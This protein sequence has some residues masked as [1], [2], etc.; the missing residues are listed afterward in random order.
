MRA[1]ASGIGGGLVRVLPCGEAAPAAAAARR[2]HAS[3]RSGS[4]APGPRRR[5]AGFRSPSVPRPAAPATPGSGVWPL[6]RPRP[7]DFLRLRM[8]GDLRAH[9]LG[10]ARDELGRGKAL[11]GE[12]VAERLVQKVRQR[13]RIRFAGLVHVARL[14]HIVRHDASSWHGTTKARRRAAGRPERRR[15]AGLVRS[16]SP[17]AAV[18]RRAAA[19][20]PIPTASGSPRSCCS[21]PRSR[22]SAP[23][24]ARFTAR[25]SD[26]RA[27]AAA[28]LD[29]VLKLW[30]GLGYYARARNLHACAKAVVERHGGRFPQSRGGA[31]RAA[32]HRPLHGG[33]DRGH[34]LRRAAQRRSTAMSSGW[35][36]GC[37]RSKRYCPAAKP[38][39]RRLTE[40]L[41]PR[42][43]AGDFA[44]A[45]MDLGATICTPKKPACA[46]CPWMEHC[47]ARARGD[48]ETFPL[49]APK[50]EGRLRRG[51]AFVV[52]RADGFV[53]V[54]SRPPKGLLGG[55]TEVPTNEWSARLR[56]EQC[57]ARGAAACRARRR[58]GCARSRR[59]DA[60][61][62]AFSARTHRLHC[63]VSA[64]DARRQPAC[65]GW[66]SPI[67]P[68]KRCPISCARCSRMRACFPAEARRPTDGARPDAKPVFTSL[69]RAL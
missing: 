17:Q 20:R 15:S 69:A 23:Y 67:C 27:L 56:R 39:I 43:R 53:L 28:P 12:R 35:W 47:A 59:R 52:M 30:A 29:D 38:D 11:L 40:A 9:D 65:A 2:P 45:L 19:R 68:A 64:P 13:T 33:G 14:C 25:W 7:L 32:R 21:R 8:G 22:R 51:A 57:A 50:K 37:S 18:A 10:P 62:H 6:E 16:P 66:R 4:P 26:V 55:M 49:K 58:N 48:P 24:F 54:R 61:V 5:G 60:R 36:R 42:E 46:L 34:R 1:V 3:R 41:V 63:R 31:C 44:Q